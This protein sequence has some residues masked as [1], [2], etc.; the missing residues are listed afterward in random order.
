M[1]GL[2]LFFL[3]S[4]L[5]CIG[6]TPAKNS[7]V[8]TNDLVKNEWVQMHEQDGIFFFVKRSECNWPEDGIF[9]EMILLKMVNTTDYNLI[10]SW[11]IL[12]WYDEE[13]WTRLPI[14]AENKHQIFLTGGEML[15]GSCERTNKYY[16]ALT[17][18]CRFLNYEDK[19]EM[20]KFELSNINISRYEK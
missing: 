9:Q 17:V 12:Q 7:F 18:F 8:V 16:S 19:P 4:P 2:M 5:I 14:R 11:D 13:L 20:T 10:I 3:L 15:E 1:K 6:Q